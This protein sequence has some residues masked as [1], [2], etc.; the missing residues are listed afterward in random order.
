MPPSP[1]PRFET[2]FMERRLEPGRH[3]VMLKNDFSDLEEKVDYYTRHTQEAEDIIRNAH[4]WIDMF[5]DQ[6]K[7]SIVR[8]H[9]FFQRRAHGGS[10]TA[11]SGDKSVHGA[12]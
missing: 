10:S 5:T 7:E 2:W 8:P 4:A 12:A 6:F 3:F 9:V 11:W 1:L